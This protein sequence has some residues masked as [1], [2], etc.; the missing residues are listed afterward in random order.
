[1]EQRKLQVMNE[2]RQQLALA[3][4]QEL[5]NVSLARF[6]ITLSWQCSVCTSSANSLGVALDFA[7]SSDVLPASNWRGAV[8]KH[9]NEA[10]VWI[11]ASTPLIE[12]ERQVVSSRWLLPQLS[13]PADPLSLQL[14]QVHHQAQYST[15]T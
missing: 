14:H 15:H 10:D 6:L 4:A 8:L 2:V 9:E 5:V 13:A 12:D 1:M 3:N 7:F 11:Y